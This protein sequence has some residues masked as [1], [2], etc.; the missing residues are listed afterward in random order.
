MP[1]AR[2]YVLA[3]DLKDDPEG[4]RTY[5]AWHKPGRTPPEVIRSI[6]SSG[7]RSLEIHLTGNR[8]LMI[9]DVEENFDPDAKASADAADPNVQ[10]WEELMWTFQQALPWAQHGEKWVAAERIF[11]LGDHP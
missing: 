8:L 7:V 9:M 5:R 11:N 2:R 1:V 6:R 3:L 10:N 4:I